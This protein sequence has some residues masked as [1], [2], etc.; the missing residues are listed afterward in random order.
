[1]ARTGWLKEDLRAVVDNLT[2]AGSLRRLS[3]A[4]LV[5]A[6]PARLEALSAETLAAVDAFH[7]KEP[8]LEGIAKQEL[9][10]RVFGGD[11]LSFA[12]VVGKL[13]EAGELAPAGEFIKRAGRAVRLSREEED[14][15][16]V[17]ESAFATAGLTVPSVAEVLSTLKVEPKRAQKIVQILVREKALVKVTEEL[18]FHRAALE[19]LAELLRGYKR[20]KGNQITVPAFKE[21]TGVTRK[22]AIPLLE[23]LD[24]RRLTRRAGDARVILA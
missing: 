18:L 21:L 9:K 20:A 12:F 5:V 15:K 7:K 14:A 23:Y 16:R 19:R 10:E 17:I 13:A 11:D 4:P 24:R 1:V 6:A 3:A 2:A 22:Y 8:L